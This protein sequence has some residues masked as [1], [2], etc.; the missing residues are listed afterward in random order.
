MKAVASARSTGGWTR[1]PR[2]ISVTATD[3][4]GIGA[5]VSRAQISLT[6]GIGYVTRKSVT[7]RN[8]DVDVYVRA[9]DRKGNPSE[10]VHVGRYKIDTTK[11]VPAA[12]AAS[13]KR[14]KTVGLRYRIADVSP[15]AVRIAIKNARGRTVKNLTVTGARPATWL[16]KSFR[17]TLARGTYRWYV[18]ATDSVGY[19]QVR[20]AVAKLIVK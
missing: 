3:D 16:T 9:F 4:A 17:C 10:V 1:T 2:T 15:C 19:K 7:V 14:G 5:G 20:P 6:G 11:P 13:V 8:G 12:K 18:S